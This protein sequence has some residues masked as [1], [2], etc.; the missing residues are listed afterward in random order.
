M[1]A[2]RL[3]ESQKKGLLEGYRL[4]KSS[5]VLAREFDCSTN[6]V[7]RTVKA[8]LGADEYQ[9]LKVARS[10]GEAAKATDLDKESVST[11]TPNSDRKEEPEPAQ[12]EKSSLETVALESLEKETVEAIGLEQSVG[13]PL[14]LDDADDFDDDLQ[15][16]SLDEEI[17]N[18]EV[19]DESSSDV[20]Q[21]VAP[22]PSSFDLNERPDIS[23]EPLTPS[24]LPGTV[25][26]L[27]DKIVE[28]D[29]RPLKEFP[30]FG[31]LAEEEQQRKA[32]CLFVNQRS[33]KRQCGRS[34]RVIKVPDSAVFRRTI[35]FLLA[36][37][38]TRI[39]L[40]GALIALDA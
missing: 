40:E 17:S 39:V 6:T 14:A 19:A 25:Y 2:S 20:F 30:E 24:T 29:V 18:L 22:L 9:A 35:P 5:T 28:L 33:A 21:E 32:L 12:G 31:F 37:G 11:K 27:V 1:A 7:N 34:Q 26:M 3:K 36:R 16:D 15:D 23:C 13:G 38:I 10:R 4:G 8:L